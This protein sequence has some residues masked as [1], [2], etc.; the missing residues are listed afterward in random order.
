MVDHPNGPVADAAK[1]FASYHKAAIDH[2]I[3]IVMPMMMEMQANYAAKLSGLKQDLSLM[4]E[5]MS[6]LQKEQSELV[7]QMDK[8]MLE[9]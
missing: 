3:Q 9:L 8:L 1:A 2:G 7:D 6:G 5:R 4:K